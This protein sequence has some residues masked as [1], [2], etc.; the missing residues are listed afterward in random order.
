MKLNVTKEKSVNLLMTLFRHS[1]F[2]NSKDVLR[3]EQKAI[4]QSYTTN[5]GLRVHT[6]TGRKAVFTFCVLRRRHRERIEQQRRQDAPL[7]PAHE[8][9]S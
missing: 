8:H 9:D 2:K 4:E 5:V 7:T 3:N 1:H 6:G